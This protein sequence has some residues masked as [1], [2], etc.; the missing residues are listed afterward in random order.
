MAPIGGGPIKSIEQRHFWKSALL[1]A[2][3]VGGLWAWHHFK[4][5]QDVQAEQAA[6]EKF[7]AHN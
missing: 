7:Q 5:R 3:I 4:I 1:L 6:Y 2:L